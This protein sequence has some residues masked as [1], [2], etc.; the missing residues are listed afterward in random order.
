MYKVI[1]LFS[2][3]VMFFSFIA[4][5]GG[6]SSSS[7]EVTLS[8]SHTDTDTANTQNGSET[9]RN[10]SIDSEFSNIAVG[11]RKVNQ[12]PLN[13]GTLFASVNGVG[14]TCSKNTPCN[15]RYAFTKVKA[16]DVLFLRGGVYRLEQTCLLENSGEKENPIII[17]SYPE[18][19]AILD[20]GKVAPED[21]AADWNDKISG[22]TLGSAVNYVYIR[23]LEVRHMDSLGITVRGS[24]NVVEGC[25]AHHNFYAGIGV[26][27]GDW[28]KDA[29]Y[30]RGYNIIQDNIVHDNSDVGLH[31][32]SGDGGN[33]DGIWIG[34]GK[35]NQVIHNTVYANSDDGIDTWRSNDTYVAYNISYDNGR[36]EGDGNGFKLGGHWDKVKDQ[37]KLDTKTG[38]RAVAEYNIAYNNKANGFDFN[39]G[40]D[41][42]M[43][44]NTAYNN[45]RY[46]YVGCK[47]AHTKV[48]HNIAAQN[49]LGS[50][51]SRSDWE[52][53]ESIDNS[54]DKEGSVKFLNTDPRSKDFLR[55]E[56]GSGFDEIGAYYDISVIAQDKNVTFVELDKAL[57]NP[58]KG[59]IIWPNDTSSPHQYVSTF[60]AIIP[61]NELENNIN[62]TVE[63]IRSYSNSNF[64]DNRWYKN[65]KYS[66]HARNIKVNPLV[67]L[68]KNKNDDFSPAD[69]NISEHDNQ[70]EEF[71]Q[72]IKNFVPKLAEAWDNDPRIGFINMGILGTWGEQSSIMM[73]PEVAKALGDS[74]STYF[75]HKKVLVRVPNYFD[76]A[77]LKSHNG[78]FWGV[79]YSHYYRFGMYWDAF[80]NETEDK[81]DIFD[82]SNL[83]KNSK[84]WIDQPI[85]GE[86]AFNM[87]YQNIYDYNDYP[88]EMPDWPDKS[89]NSIHDTLTHQD[90]LDYV[91]DYI[92]SVHCTG[93]SWISGYNESN[94]EEAKAAQELQK[95]MGYRFVLKQASYNDTMKSGEDFNVSF[96]VKNSGSAPFYY[97]W[98]VEIALLDL[99]SKKVVWSDQF[100]TVDIR[101]WL[102]GE[103]WDFDANRYIKS[104]KTYT[105]KEHFVLPANLQSGE[106]ILALSINDPAGNHPSVRFSVINQY[107]NGRTPIGI[108]GINVKPSEVLP[109][110]DDV[111]TV[112]VAYD[113]VLNEN[114]E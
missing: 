108:V 70:T 95:I 100:N 102:P 62:D 85:L 49:H 84:L 4:C 9:I 53:F 26:S 65:I 30:D 10:E 76:K 24:H 29:P 74:F 60:K 3:L 21:V 12:T 94:E 33:A 47:L 32:G 50:R 92:R 35:H 99:E 51:F 87:R 107:N 54:W 28:H 82:T 6:D 66:V 56:K 19:M 68:K 105:V 18:E 75:K 2:I 97:N 14:E 37:P 78:S 90:S 104:A 109:K 111:D 69:M 1:K 71:I 43:R 64:F 22:I 31:G 46:G 114:L 59:F 34:A 57:V 23:K 67:L 20:G 38:L 98:P 40:M 55:P 48:S 27:G 7:N 45:G 36:S 113:K 41:V 101:E 103:A 77:Y 91:K 93:L 11:H 79:E 72:R 61:W 16:G 5:G 58:L 44:Y 73:R 89:K 112:K 88:T 96:S 83:I 39:L 15:L 17:E 25:N 86:V 52:D 8:P 81:K 42:V 106:Y 80:A 13:K 63:K 110:F